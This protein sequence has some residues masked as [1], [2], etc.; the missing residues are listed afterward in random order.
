MKTKAPNFF[1]II[2]SIALLWNLIGCAAY[3]GMQMIPPELLETMPEAER[4]LMENTPVWAT[5]A[6][7][8]AVWFGL[9]GSTYCCCGKHFHKP[10]LLFHYWELLYSNYGI[11]LMANRWRCL[12]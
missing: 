6:F 11:L 4:T 9:L 5:A 7:A 1:W 3:L 12:V 2:S 8:V 10:Y